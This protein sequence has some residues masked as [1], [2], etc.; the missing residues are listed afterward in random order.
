MSAA[1]MDTL[2]D[3]ETRWVAYCNNPSSSTFLDFLTPIAVEILTANKTNPDL[4]LKDVSANQQQS[5]GLCL[6]KTLWVEEIKTCV[7]SF[8]I[9]EQEHLLHLLTAHQTTTE[10]TGKEKIIEEINRFAKEKKIDP[11]KTTEKVMSQFKKLVTLLEEEEDDLKRIEARLDEEVAEAKETHEFYQKTFDQ[12]VQYLRDN[13]MKRVEF[14]YEKIKG[15][16]LGEES[17]FFRIP[18]TNLER[19][20][21]DIE[22][23]IFNQKNNLK[24]QLHY[25]EIDLEFFQKKPAKNKATINDLTAKREALNKEM[26]A[27]EEQE[28]NKLEAVNKQIYEERALQA[29]KLEERQRIEDAARQQKLQEQKAAYDSCREWSVRRQQREDELNQTLKQLEEITERFGERKRRQRCNI[30]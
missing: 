19:K 30:L 22:M 29:K 8:Q 20:R 21:D 17:H 1:T 11:E 28:K 6:F 7:D 25:I 10:E 12:K 3:T 27:C 13:E 18:K 5:E 26:D 23:E 15:H 4:S 24:N 2:T 16:K 14:I 9:S